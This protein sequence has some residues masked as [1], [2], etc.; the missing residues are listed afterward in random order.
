MKRMKL[1]AV[2][3]CLVA[4]IGML[5]GCKTSMDLV[6]G[7]VGGET[8]T[9]RDVTRY[10]DYMLLNNGYSRGDL[11]EEDLAGLNESALENAIHY[12]VICRKAAA[13]GLY[14]LSEENQKIADNN[15]EQYMASLEASYLSAYQQQAGA[16]P[17]MDFEALASDAADSYLSSMGLTEEDLRTLMTVFEASD[18]L[19]EETT[20][21]IAVTDDE[22]LARYNEL[23]SGQQADYASDP[24]AY[25]T[26][27]TYG[28]EIVVYRPEGYRFVKHILISMPEDI[29]TQITAAASGGDT[30]TAAA[31]REQGLAQIKDKAEEVLAKV[32]SGEDFDALITQYGGDPGMQ[33]E[34]AKTQGY[35]VGAESSYVAEF[36]EAAM[37]LANV[38]DTTGLVATDYGYHIIKYVGDVPSGAIALD[39]V[40][41]G[42]AADLL[43]GKQSDAYDALVE[44]WKSET[45]I[46]KNVKKIPIVTGGS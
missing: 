26:A 14:P 38:G 19:M 10:A 40:R 31:L 35:Q 12:K 15:F 46:K 30:E 36:L 13:L 4:I 29:E 37:G 24:T 17:N 22:V 8:I 43:V 41:S 39:E 3:L 21:E 34:P 18:V 27:L 33:A 5:A 6:V 44:Q 28:T 23:L 45:T 32:Q 11:T 1:P 2:L 9:A 20:G 7:S 25:D 42:I 16:D